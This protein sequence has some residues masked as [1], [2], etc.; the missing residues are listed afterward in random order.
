MFVGVDGCPEGWLAVVYSESGFE[1]AR[2]YAS[3][4][5]I[6]NAHRS[7]ERICI[8][9]PIGL[10]NDSS[11]P[12]ACDTAAR[13]KLSPHRH[14]SVF[15]TPIRPAAREPTYT[16]AKQVQ[17]ACT[18]G[19]LNRQTW[20]ITPKIDEVDQFLLKTPRARDVFRECHPEVCL[21][22]FT[23]EAMQF[24]KLG[25][26][27]R[28]YWERVDALR[29]VEPSVYD[30]LW[31][32][33]RSGLDGASDDDLIDAF[34]TALTAVGPRS[35]LQTLPADPTIDDEGLPMEIVYRSPSAP[36]SDS[37]HG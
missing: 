3:I 31:E 30:H 28:G 7:A 22:A 4:T 14:T 34:A 5:D 26:P 20:G 29:T 23:G 13:Q 8:D 17:E 36:E 10:R 16:A 21:W 6:W 27:R 1:T 32:A 18:D 2:V 15:P 33:T 25:E 19:S 11:E 9:V 37:S 12:R 24:S 35:Q